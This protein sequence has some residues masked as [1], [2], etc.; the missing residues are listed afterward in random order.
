MASRWRKNK[1]LARV[2]NNIAFH[3]AEKVMKRGVISACKAGERVTVLEGDSRKGGHAHL[4]LGINLLL[5]GMGVDTDDL[6]R[7]IT[8]TRHD[9]VRLTRLVQGV[10]AEA[11]EGA[12]VM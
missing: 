11:L 3:V 7:A 9:H 12:G 5:G 6:K 8:I 10:F 1:L 4:S 2:R